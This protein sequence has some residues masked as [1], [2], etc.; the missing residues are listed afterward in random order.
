MDLNLF[1]E[2]ISWKGE[3]GGNVRPLKATVLWVTVMHLPP[4]PHHSQNQLRAATIWAPV[5]GRHGQVGR[6]A[7]MGGK[8]R[9]A[10]VAARAAKGG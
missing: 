3:V 6:L 7:R 8:V 4:R 9:A 5:A 2:E 10:G 1:K